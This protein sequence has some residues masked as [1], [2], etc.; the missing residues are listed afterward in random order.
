MRTAQQIITTLREESP[1][2]L[3]ISDEEIDAFTEEDISAI[4]VEFGASVL[5]KLPAREQ[6]FMQWLR[7]NDAGV[8]DDL[9]EDDEMLLVSLSFL[10]DFRS[11]G[12]G[13]LICELREHNNYF[14]TPKHVKPEG[15][16]GLKGILKKVENKLE[17]AIEEALMFE[18]IRG[19]VDIWHF[20]HRH[21]VP[22]ARGKAAVQTLSSHN[23]LVHLP[24]GEDLTSYLEE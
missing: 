18:I 2:I 15:A 24:L 3:E 16:A 5:M 7:E 19:P 17:L 12:R 23:W 1:A 13:F 11:G 4:Q 21:G 10:P 22:L 20:C 9:W 8:Y 14:F 6:A